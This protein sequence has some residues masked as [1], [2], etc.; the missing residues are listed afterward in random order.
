MHAGFLEADLPVSSGVLVLLSLVWSKGPKTSTCLVTVLD[1]G[2]TCLVLG[3]GT[4]G[5]HLV[6][7]RKT[8]VP[9]VLRAEAHT[10]AKS[11]VRG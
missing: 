2:T 6:K 4:C 8:A 1:H 5:K 3:H 7:N 10:P 11:S 9:R